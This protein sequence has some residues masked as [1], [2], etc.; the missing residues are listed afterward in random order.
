MGARKTLKSLLNTHSGFMPPAPAP[1]PKSEV[2]TIQVNNNSADIEVHTES[3]LFDIP[4]TQGKSIAEF[5]DEVAPGYAR[6]S[7]EL[8]RKAMAGQADPLAGDLPH[9]MALLLAGKVVPAR[10]FS[11]AAPEKAPAEVKRNKRALE[12]LLAT[13]APDAEVAG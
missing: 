12:R 4:A 6:A 9:R 1:A 11:D 3:P 7:F 10:R 13:L 2:G 5:V 8:A